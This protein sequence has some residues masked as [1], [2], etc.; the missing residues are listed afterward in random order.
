MKD[1]GPQLPSDYNES[2]I[3]IFF[4]YCVLTYQQVLLTISCTSKSI[5]YFLFY[6]KDSIKRRGF[7]INPDLHQEVSQK[8]SNLKMYTRYYLWSLSQ[9]SFRAFQVA[10][11]P[12]LGPHF[13]LVLKKDWSFISVFSFCTSSR[14]T[15]CM[16][17]TPAREVPFKDFR[18]RQRQGSTR[19]LL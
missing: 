8:A 18:A 15:Q 1:S 11:N 2:L 17:E 19:T 6:S 14:A 4:L 3:K 5:Q 7:K 16:F 12:C 13:C 9:R 10:Q